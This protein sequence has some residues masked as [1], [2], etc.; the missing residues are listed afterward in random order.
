MGRYFVYDYYTTA[1]SQ[2]QIAKAICIAGQAKD[3][4]F[5]LSEGNDE[6]DREYVCENLC[7]WIAQ[8]GHLEVL[9]WARST[10]EMY[11]NGYPWNEITCAGAAENGHLNI[12]QW[13]HD[14]GCPWNWLTCDRAVRGKHLNILQWMHEMHANDCPWDWRTCACAALGGHLEILQ[15]AREQFLHFRY[16]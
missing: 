2:S 5:I 4:E 8:G 7:T 1:S 6:R 12:L 13:A 9:K 15:W 3:I 16:V 14:N 11:E 10:H